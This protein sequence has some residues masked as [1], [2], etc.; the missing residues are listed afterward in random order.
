MSKPLATVADTL[1][2]RSLLQGSVTP[3]R[4]ASVQSGADTTYARNK[5]YLKEGDHTYNTPLS[6]VEEA[7][8][9]TWVR[10][11]SVPFDANAKVTDYDMRGFWKALTSGDKRAT[12]AVD[13]NDRRLH[14]PDYWKTPYHETFSAESQW[15]NPKT[16]PKWNDKDQLVLPNGTVIYDDRKPN[17]RR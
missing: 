13:P 10:H 1:A 17:G 6:P 9:R 4:R 11:N 8:F 14:Y 7:A 12:T 5:A 3:Q 16:A 15:A 2:P